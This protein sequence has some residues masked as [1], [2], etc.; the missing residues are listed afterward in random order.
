MRGFERQG[1]ISDP[2]VTV[3][4]VPPLL[5]AVWTRP[6]PKVAPLESEEVILFKNENGAEHDDFNENNGKS[7]SSYVIEKSVYP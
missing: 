4:T 7:K 3:R 6:T 1:C 5:T 2:M